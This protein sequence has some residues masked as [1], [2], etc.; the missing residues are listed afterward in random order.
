MQDP[1]W[2][3][4]FPVLHC[5]PSKSSRL[6]KVFGPRLCPEDQPQRVTQT[7]ARESS[8]GSARASRCGWAPPQPRSFSCGSARLCR[9]EFVDTLSGGWYVAPSLATGH[10]LQEHIEFAPDG[11]SHESRSGRARAAAVGKMA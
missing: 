6:A 10:G 7:T 8:N 3:A 9:A 11:L 2:Y 1:E 5:Y 4:P